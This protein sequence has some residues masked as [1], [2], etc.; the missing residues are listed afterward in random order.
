MSDSSSEEDDRFKQAVDP[1]LFSNSMFEDTPK[2][3]K[4]Q[5]EKGENTI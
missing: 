2:D 5:P 1:S 3:K 4:K